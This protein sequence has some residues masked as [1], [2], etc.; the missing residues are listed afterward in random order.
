MYYSYKE[1]FGQGEILQKT[2]HYVIEKELEIQK[3]WE[4]TIFEEIVFVACGSSYWASMSA[5]M[6][7]QE[8][9]GKE[10]SMVK[11]GEVVMNPEFYRKRY[12]N[13]L[14]I[15]P[16]RSG[17]TTETVK[18][19]E[20][21]KE[22]YGSKVFA[23]VEYEN[24]AVE[25]LADYCLHLPWANETSIC[26]TR[27]FS[28][29]YMSMILVAGIWS[30]NNVLTKDL[31]RYADHAEKHAVEAESLIQKITDE[32][33]EW[34]SLVALGQGKQYGVVVEGAYINIEMA[35]LPAHY[36]SILEWRH[37]PIVLSGVSYLAAITAG[38]KEARQLEE[39]MAKETRDTGA[40]VLAIS[41]NQDFV[42]ADYK[43]SLGWDACQETTA[44]FSVMVLQGIAYYQALRKGINPDKPGNLVSW[45]SI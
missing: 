15:A 27:S 3:F 35:Q 18:A 2:W 39:A 38:S 11:S 45:I 32:F 40:K 19:L 5:C 41:G 22:A 16:S 9:T 31:K 24:S 25:A 37:G 29:L 42:Q 17:S 28:S 33:K 43:I 8:Q 30:G 7:M 14:V 10:C 26:Q 13:P 4:K 34:E 6:T 20:L 23:L 21:F 36:F 1:I 44:L 12:R